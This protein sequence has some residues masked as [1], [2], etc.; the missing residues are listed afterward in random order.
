VGKVSELVM[1]SDGEEVSFPQYPL[2]SVLAEICDLGEFH[3][4]PPGPVQAEHLFVG[5]NI[6][7]L[8][9]SLAA[10]AWHESIS[11]PVRFWHDTPGL[12]DVYGDVV[13][14]RNLSTPDH[15]VPAN[16]QNGFGLGSLMEFFGDYEGLPSVSKTPANAKEF[17]YTGQY[18]AEKV[19][20][21]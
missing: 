9:R 19:G 10:M 3:G 15:A 18:L 21:I 14:E 4:M 7:A 13:P 8:F 16:L 20:L 17:A 12:L 1:L 2:E 6:R 5:I 11:L